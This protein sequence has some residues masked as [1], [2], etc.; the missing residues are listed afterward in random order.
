MG[1]RNAKYLDPKLQ[2]NTV[3]EDTVTDKQL[4]LVQDDIIHFRFDSGLNKTRADRFD[5]NGNF[6]D[7][8][9]LENVHNL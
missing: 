6:V 7:T 3:R 9:D 8:V 2:S 1:G 5:N 4:N